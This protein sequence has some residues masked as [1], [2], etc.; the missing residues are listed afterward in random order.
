[1]NHGG[2]QQFSQ[3]AHTPIFRKNRFL[4]KIPENSEEKNRGFI[5]F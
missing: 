3:N 2:I 5:P 1:L 4:G